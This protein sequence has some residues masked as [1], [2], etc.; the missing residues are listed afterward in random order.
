M[1]P[2]ASAP[3]CDLDISCPQPTGADCQRR[4]LRFLPLPRRSARYSDRG[5]RRSRGLGGHIDVFDPDALHLLPPESNS[6]ATVLER[7]NQL[8][9]HNIHYT[10]FA[11]VFLASFDYNA[12]QV[13]YANAGHNP[14]LLY[15]PQ[16]TSGLTSLSPTGAAIGLLDDIHWGSPPCRWSPAIS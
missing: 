2:P 4:P 7:I 5:R 13:T 8:F 10:T 9:L 15:C 3:A 11:T 1:L 14:P 16:A 12:Q 6:P